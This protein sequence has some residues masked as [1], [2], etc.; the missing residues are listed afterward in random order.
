MPL[1]VRLLPSTS[2]KVTQKGD[3]CICGGQ[4]RSSEE[5]QIMRLNMG[6]HIQP[7]RVHVS[8]GLQHNERAANG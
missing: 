5:T 8:C 6:T 7:K 3:F 4:M 1:E 2:P